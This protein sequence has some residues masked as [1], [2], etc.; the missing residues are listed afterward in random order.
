MNT[1]APPAAAQSA[2]HTKPDLETQSAQYIANDVTHHAVSA[3]RATSSQIPQNHGTGREA[4]QRCEWEA[5]YNN[6]SPAERS[7]WIKRALC[8][9]HE[10]M[11]SLREIAHDLGLRCYR[12]GE[13]KIAFQYFTWA[14]NCSADA[15]YYLGLIYENGHGMPPDKDLALAW[16]RKAADQ[17]HEDALIKLGAQEEEENAKQ[18]EKPKS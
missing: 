10:T 1:Q 2:A 12:L 18:K 9:I 7:Q 13:Y 3:R 8:E 17:G 14:E 5:V 15:R 6:I 16:Y 11:A 4:S